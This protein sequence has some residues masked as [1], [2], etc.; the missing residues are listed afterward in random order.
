MELW[1]DGWMYYFL[2]IWRNATTS[3]YLKLILCVIVVGGFFNI[4]RSN[5][6]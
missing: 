5:F 6:K 3:D 4:Q 2:D 1:I